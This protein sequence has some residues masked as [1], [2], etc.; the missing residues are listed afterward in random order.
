MAWDVNNQ[1]KESLRK[2]LMRRFSTVK[3]LNLRRR[4][5]AIEFEKEFGREII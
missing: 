5:T 1:A 2:K 4:S 3:V